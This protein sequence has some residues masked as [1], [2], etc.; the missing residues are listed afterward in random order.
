MIKKV[1]KYG[2][3]FDSKLELYMYEL[4]VK[5][6]LKFEFQVEYLLFDKIKYNEE[7]LRKM[8]LT[9][10]FVVYT[11][12]CPVIVDTKGFFRA[13]NKL[14]WKLFKYF[15][16]SRGLP[17]PAI[18]FPSSQV[19]CVELVEKLKVGDLSA[20]PKKPKRIK[21]PKKQINNEQPNQTSNKSRRVRNSKRY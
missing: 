21:N 7:T 16:S 9:V 10:D 1:Y 20:I 15:L 5:S 14:R 17:T 8:T 2:L 18:F 19:E 6:K 13:E 3:K 4:L 11:K 12:D